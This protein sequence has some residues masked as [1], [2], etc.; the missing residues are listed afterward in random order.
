MIALDF[1]VYLLKTNDEALHY[2]MICKAEVE[3]NLKGKSN[4]WGLIRVESIF[5]PSLLHFAKSLEF[6]MRG[7]LSIHPSQMG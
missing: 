7:C 5:L 6:F 3:T 1:V 4:S 2:F